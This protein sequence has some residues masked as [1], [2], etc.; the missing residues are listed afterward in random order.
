MSPGPFVHNPDLQ[1]LRDEGYTVAIEESGYVTIR[2][3]AYVTPERTVSRDGIL[4]YPYSETG[5][6]DHIVYFAGK[7]PGKRDGSPFGFSSEGS[8]TVANDAVAT[9]QLSAKDPD[10]QID[11]DYYVKFKRYLTI[12]GNQAEAVEA[13]SS[14]PPHRPISA[15]DPD[16]PFVYLDS[17]TSRAG[18]YEYAKRLEQPRVAI[19][20]LGGT[21]SYILD[22]VSKTRVGEIHLF[23]GDE[24]LSHNAF[25]APGAI[26]K[27]D[28]D[29]E[30]RARKADYYAKRYGV[31]KRNII[32]HPYN[33][34][35]SNA[36]ELAGMSFVFL[37]MEGGAV[38]RALVEAMEEMDLPFIDASIDVLPMGEGLGGTVQVTASVPGY[39]DH[40]RSRVDFSDPEPDDI[41][42]SNIQVADL[43][44]LN[45][46]LAVIKWKKL[47]GFYSDVRRE[48]W[49]AYGVDANVLISE[50]E[51]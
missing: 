41:Y 35:G 45:A 12:L 10:A 14:E 36:D 5:P 46:V 2:D 21:G 6:T 29:V 44:A 16:S 51:S 23:D 11:A 38:K 33:L 37:A 18:T 49:S 20:G 34:D 47:N 27:E 30:S 4:A 9:F 28:L 25:R 7:K 3:V 15:D 31:L 39:R 17:A 43:N 13:G 50:D 32:S 40:L 42:S 48:H 26:P 24:L 19:V 8:W 22:L 1:R